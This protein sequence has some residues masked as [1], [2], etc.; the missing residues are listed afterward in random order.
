MPLE[1]TVVKRLPTGAQFWDA[2]QKVLGKTLDPIAAQMAARAPKGRTGKLS[3]RIAVV[4]KRM[5]SGLI[6]GVEADFVTG[7][8]YGHLV[9][10]GHRIVARGPNRRTR[11]TREERRDL[12]RALLRRRLQAQGF[13]PANPFA[14]NVLKEQRSGIITGIESGLKQEIDRAV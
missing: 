13:V 14:E 4:L 6:Q 12:R 5:N 11:M 8:K 2:V 3:R 1:V 10:R 9:E 7:V